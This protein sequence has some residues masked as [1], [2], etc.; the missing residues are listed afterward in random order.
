MRVKDLAAW[1]KAGWEGDG[2]REIRRVAALEDA[3]PG[4]L[5]FVT[6]GRAA[7]FAAA[8]RASCLLVPLPYTNEAQQT[9]IRTPE[10]RSA[11]AKVI[12][13]LHPRPEAQSSLTTFTLRCSD[14]IAT[15]AGKESG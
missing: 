14:A 13:K 1:L 3:G 5:S 7:K 6:P 4:D 10:P 15:F 12:P 11:I 8:S 2:E 9:I